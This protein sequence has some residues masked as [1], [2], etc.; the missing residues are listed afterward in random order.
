MDEILNT[1]NEGEL[2][3]LAHKQGYGHLR[4]GIPREQLIDLVRGVIPCSPEFLAGTK[5][6]RRLLESFIEKHFEKVRSQ[7]PGCN[8]KCTSFPC[9]EG[10]H[11][12]CFTGNRDV[13]SIK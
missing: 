8:G 5:D 4:R 11:A 6:S 1:L 3:T 10:K 12:V 9:S 13:I 7:L 2:I